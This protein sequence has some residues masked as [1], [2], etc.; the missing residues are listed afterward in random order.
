MKKIN[1]YIDTET[2]GL[3]STE[4]GITQISIL[5]EDE[6][7][8]IIDT[9]DEYIRPADECIITITALEIQGITREDLKT[10]KYQE[11]KIVAD[12]LQKFLEKYQEHDLN[13]IG[14]NVPFDLG[15]LDSFLERNNIN[16]DINSHRNTDVLE[17]VRS[18]HLNMYNSL[19]NACCY[20]GVNLENAHNS[21]GDV[22]ATR[23]LYHKLTKKKK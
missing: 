15:F 5:I 3:E 19:T 10:D 12:K 7:G 14:Y 4:N 17:M 22:T 2:T 23:D 9:F 8:K 11:E 6:K 13:I 21:L 1:F 20:F 16:F 18:Y